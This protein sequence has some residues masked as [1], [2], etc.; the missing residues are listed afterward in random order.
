MNRRHPF[1]LL[2]L[3]VAAFAAAVLM[4]ALLVAMGGAWRLQQRAADLE[5][6][7][8]PRETAF[9]R[10]RQEFQAAVPPRGIL[11]GPLLS[12]AV[13]AG[14]WRHDDVEWTAAIGATNPDAPLTTDLV[15]VHYYLTATDQADVYRLVRTQRPSVPATEETT[16]EEIVILDG[17]VSFLLTW[18]D[19]TTWQDAW[20][21][22]AQ[23]NQL[24]QAVWVRLDFAERK[25]IRPKPLELI[26]PFAMRTPGAQGGS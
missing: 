19:G 16:P 23:Q 10:L 26:V 3:L 5:S 12:Q 17:V 2:E 21:S 24:P 14:D 4:A 20:D 9:L 1:T 15:I 25:G 7:E 22:S 18:Y 6:A 13:E 8:I 11:A